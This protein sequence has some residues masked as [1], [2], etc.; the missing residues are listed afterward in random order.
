MRVALKGINTV[1]K[2]LSGGRIARYHSHRETGIR[3][4]GEPGSPEFIASYSRAEQSVR[5]R[6]TTGVFASLVR[7]YMRSPEFQTQLADST[8]REYGRKLAFAETE[9]G[10]LPITA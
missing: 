7:D 8:R 3:L 6:H 4:E 2:R 9:F 5:E 10:D 1:R